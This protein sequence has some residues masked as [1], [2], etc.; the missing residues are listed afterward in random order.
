MSSQTSFVSFLLP[1]SAKIQVNLRLPG[2]VLIAQAALETGWGKSI[3][4][5]MNTGK[6][7]FNLFNIKGQ[8]TNGSVLVKTK[9]YINGNYITENDEFRAYNNFSES[10][11]D[12]GNLLTTAKYPNGTLIYAAGLAVRN[13]PIAYINAVAPIYATDPNYATEVINIM[14]E[15]NLIE[16]VSRMADNTPDE[17]AEKQWEACVAAKIFDGTDPKG[18]L[19][20]EMLAVLLVALNLVK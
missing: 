3:D 10:I 5:D 8:G 14:K 17:W 18:V 1:G 15:Y 7:S 11:V 9:E 13:N 20:R 16:E 12:Y 4:V 2:A 6:Y 19:T